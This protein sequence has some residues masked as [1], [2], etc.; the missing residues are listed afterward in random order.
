MAT[1][2]KLYNTGE[3]LRASKEYEV[4]VKAS[5]TLVPARVGLIRAYLKMEKVKDAFDSANLGLAEDLNSAPLHSVMGD[6]RFRRGEL[7]QAEG[8]YRSALNT[9]K[10]NIDAILG[11]ARIYTAFSLHKR[12]YEL[13]NAAHKIAPDNPEVQRAWL[14]TLSSK[15]RIQA[16]EEYLKGSHGETEETK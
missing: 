5:P 15:E 2:E 12:A 6:V 10:Q 4:L 3:F 14:R 1:A 11:L 13:V 7:A 8:E 9:D 16:L